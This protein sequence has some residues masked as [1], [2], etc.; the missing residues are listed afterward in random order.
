MMSRF[1]WLVVFVCAFGGDLPLYVCFVLC[2]V[3]LLFFCGVVDGLLFVCC[4]FLLVLLFDV[5]D[6]VSFGWCGSLRSRVRFCWGASS[7]VCLFCVICSAVVFVF[8][9]CVRRPPA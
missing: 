8:F 6:D 3:L 7:L 9:L 4:I 2:V 5:F 1:L